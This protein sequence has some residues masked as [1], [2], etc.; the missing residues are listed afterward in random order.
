MALPENLILSADDRS[1]LLGH[2]RELGKLLSY[3]PLESADA[4]AETLVTVTKMLMVLPGAKS[5]ETGNEARGEAY[6]AALDDVPP[7]AV[8]EAV[9]K[10]YRG[11]HG[12]KY[13]YR[14][15]PV[16][17]D[18]RSL[19]YVEQFRIKNRITMLER[20]ANAEPLVEYS[21]EHRKMMLDRLAAVMRMPASDDEKPISQE[22]A[23]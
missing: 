21:D 17:A 9:R 3:T 20:V 18:L 8:H 5:S 2:A 11:E 7:W 16:P 23:A 6:L 13:D 4:E 12:T 14:W 10:W 22:D 19:A 15:A 1:Q